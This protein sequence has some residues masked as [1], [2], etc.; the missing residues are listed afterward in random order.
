MYRPL[1]GHLQ[2]IKVHKIRTASANP[3]LYGKVE[4]SNLG[5]TITHKCQHKMLVL[6]FIYIGLYIIRLKDSDLNLTIQK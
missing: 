6:H 4:I 3:F 2:D 5:V 1:G